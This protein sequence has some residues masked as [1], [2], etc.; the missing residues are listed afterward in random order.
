[1]LA[2]ALLE[3]DKTVD[4][5][6]DINPRKMLVSEVEK[7]VY[8]WIQSI[9]EQHFENTENVTKSLLEVHRDIESAKYSFKGVV[10]ASRARNMTK[11][12]GN[13]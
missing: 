11:L 6:L 8:L 10:D 1:M 4:I 7:E 9:F 5:N 2:S 3:I 12:N 13:D